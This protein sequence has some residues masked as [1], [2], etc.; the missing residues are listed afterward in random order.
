M[1]AGGAGGGAAG[2]G[3]GNDCGPARQGHRSRTHRSPG[4]RPPSQALL[5]L[6]VDLLGHQHPPGQ[7]GG[8]PLGL[9]LGLGQLR[10]RRRSRRTEGGGG[11]LHDLGLDDAAAPGGL[12][13]HLLRLLDRAGA[14][15]PL[16]GAWTGGEA[17]VLLH[18]VGGGSRRPTG[19]EIRGVVGSV[20]RGLFF[21]RSGGGGGVR[22]R[23]SAATLVKS[24]LQ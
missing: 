4:S 16:A 1:A 19:V 15:G 2:P 9:G 24:S 6:A 3:L 20:G 17:P 22:F 10:R 7:K 23:A 11:D 13:G 8:L 14:S 12:G 5:F 18:H 21:G